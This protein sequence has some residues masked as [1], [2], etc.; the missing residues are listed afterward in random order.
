VTATE[1]T[2]DDDIAAFA[3]ALAEVLA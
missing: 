2:T 1:C 3:S